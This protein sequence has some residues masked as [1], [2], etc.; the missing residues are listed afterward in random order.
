MDHGRSPLSKEGQRSASLC[1]FLPVTFSPWAKSASNSISPSALAEE[2]IA[3]S[4]IHYIIK[5]TLR[6]HRQGGGDVAG[7]G[8]SWAEDFQNTSA[9]GKGRLFYFIFLPRPTQTSVSWSSVT[10]QGGTASNKTSC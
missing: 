7:G 10:E 1:H 3:S 9:A 8:R 6:S 4:K 2:T 5:N